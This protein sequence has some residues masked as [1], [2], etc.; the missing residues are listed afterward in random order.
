ML[1]HRNGLN[2]IQVAQ[3]HL[4]ISFHFT[5]ERTMNGIEHHGFDTVLI[6]LRHQDVTRRCL[7][8]M[9]RAFS[10]E[11]VMRVPVCRRGG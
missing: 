9:Q 4:V 6:M 8:R 11:V 3:V 1:C 10:V 5:S 7:H 2:R